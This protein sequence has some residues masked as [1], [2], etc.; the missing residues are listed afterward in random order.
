MR[1]RFEGFFCS[2]TYF[3]S[4]TVEYGV[5]RWDVHSQRWRWIVPNEK[6]KYDDNGFRI[7]YDAVWYLPDG[8]YCYRAYAAPPG[9]DSRDY[10]IIQNGEFKQLSAPPP[11]IPH[12]P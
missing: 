5:Y 11:G 9:R 7:L 12:S 8:M 6:K 2:G 10:F 1:Y 3:G 4:G